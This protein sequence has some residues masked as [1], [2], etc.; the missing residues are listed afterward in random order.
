MAYTVSDDIPLTIGVNY[1]T[2]ANMFSGMKDKDSDS[3][4]DIFDDF[5]EDSTLWNDTDGDGWPDP[6]HGD[7]VVDSLIDID[8]DGDNIIVA[9]ENEDEIELKAT[10]FS[11]KNNKAITNALS[12]DIGYPILDS[13][14][15]TLK[16]YSEYNQLNFPG[17]I[18]SLIH[19]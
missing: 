15:M 2:D 12:F 5:P 10:P 9:N 19:I 17:F 7:S 16:V 6:G 3:Y 11:L 14:L 8:A 13:D 4:P 1:I 18:L